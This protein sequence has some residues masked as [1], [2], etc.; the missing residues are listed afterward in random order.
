MV[1]EVTRVLKESGARMVAL[2]ALAKAGGLAEQSFPQVLELLARDRNSDTREQ[3]ARTLGAIGDHKQA[4]PMNRKVGLANQAKPV[5]IRAIESDKDSDVRKA[6]IGCLMRLQ[7]EPPEVVPILEKAAVEDSD[8]RVILAAL[9]GL[10]DF[11]ADARSATPS[12]ERLLDHPSPGVQRTA[13]AT[14]ASVQLDRSLERKRRVETREV[15]V[16]DPE[17]EKRGLE[18]LRRLGVKFEERPFEVAIKERQI[19]VI[20]AFLDAG[21]SPN[22]QFSSLSFT[23]LHTLFDHACKTSVRPTPE[24]VKTVARLLLRRG[25]DPNQFSAGSQNSP[26]VIALWNCDPAVVQMLLE[27][28]AN[29]SVKNGFGQTAVVSAVQYA[30]AMGGDGY[31]AL[32]EKGHVLSPEEAKKLCEIHKDDPKALELVSRMSPK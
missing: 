13:K 28:G 3:A 27:A 19:N 31:E 23:P 21:M 12:I 4:I 7:L 1:P 16:K 11:E 25:A 22:H 32:I 10:R 14:L 30:A 18:T 15:V 26:L 24:K 9:M 8:E 29:P 2:R 5:L 20:E 17:A 6:A